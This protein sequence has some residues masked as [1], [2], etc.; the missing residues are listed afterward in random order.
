MK[1]ELFVSSKC[2]DCIN[3]FENEKTNPKYTI[4]KDVEIIDITESMTN[5]KRFLAYRDRLE[6]YNEIKNLG[7]VGVPSMVINQKDVDII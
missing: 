3:L 2:I 5:L 1:K 4:D 6:G 7:Y